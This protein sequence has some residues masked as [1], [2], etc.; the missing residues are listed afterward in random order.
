MK[1]FAAILVSVLAF[2]PMFALASVNI[3]LS[4]GAVSVTR[5]SSYVE[6]GYS[7]LSTIDG[8]VTGNVSVTNPGTGTVGKFTILY[9]VT[10]SALDTATASRDLT[11]MGGGSGMIF[12]SGPMAPG[13]NTSLPD[14]GCNSQTQFVSFGGPLKDGTKCEFF[15]GCMDVK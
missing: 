9:S 2:A 4:G 15:M 5:G 10:D 6:P 12:C 1:K 14:G 8:D 7:A 11:V 13:W 3:D